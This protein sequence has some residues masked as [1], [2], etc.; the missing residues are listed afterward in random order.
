MHFIIK[1]RKKSYHNPM[2]PVNFKHVQNTHGYMR[3]TMKKVGIQIILNGHD[4]NL[5]KIW[6]TKIMIY[7]K[8]FIMCISEN[9]SLI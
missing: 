5:T 3:Y 4:P 1:C 9:R 7:L 8:S 2:Q 6:T